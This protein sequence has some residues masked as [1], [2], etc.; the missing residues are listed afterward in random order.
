M[1]RKKFIKQEK[2]S[3]ILKKFEH[4]KI[5]LCHGVFDLLHLGHI[6]H[7]KE[8]KKKV[9]V[10]IVS[11]TS[12]KFVNKGPGRPAF[13]HAQR[14]KCLEAI[15][16]IDYV[17]ISDTKS[18]VQIINKIKPNI[19]FK[20]PDYSKEED[21]LTGKILL[22]KNAVKK[23]G[24]IIFNTTAQKFS[25]T[26]LIKDYLNIPS[27]LDNLKLKVSQNLNFNIVKELFKKFK[28]NK[29]LIVGEIVIDQYNFTDT[30]GKAGKEPILVLNEKFSEKY[31]GGSGAICRHVNQLSDKVTLLS[32][33]GEKKEQLN[34][35]KSKLGKKIHTYFINK[36]DSP[37]IIKKRYVD[38]ISNAKII[39][40]YNINDKF[41]TSSEES[42][43]KNYFD[44]LY[45]KN[46]LIIISDYG[47]GLI[48]NK[49]AKYICSKSKFVAVN[50]Q[51]NSS[52]IGYHSLRFYKN[53]NLV[54]IN[55]N[56]LRYEMR[57]K[58]EKIEKLLKSLSYDLNLDYVVVTKGR[59]GAIMF[60][61]KNNNFYYAPAFAKKTIDKVGAGDA[62]LSVMGICLF[63]KI[64]CQLSLLISSLAAAQA[65]EIMGNKKS[66]QKDNLL[67]DLEFLIK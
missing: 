7:F 34:F 8:A 28:N 46:D 24:G 41:L 56:E 61:K 25:S 21:D 53:A 59:S 60:S 67:K 9:D 36:S 63:N 48:T 15:E 13:N 3:N 52:N 44:K 33:I 26:Q 62:M 43:F 4:K 12:D 23:H 1:I 16:Y 66:I 54:I 49:M 22:E 39:G 65:V 20:G 38:S 27:H 50:V 2:I 5:G 19:Y 40:C 58:T 47:H 42:K 17:T 10:L 35:I 29:A 64:D 6:L 57:S 18:G 51:I 11:I 32:Y 31:L 55:E 14:I 37:T 30:L 45:K